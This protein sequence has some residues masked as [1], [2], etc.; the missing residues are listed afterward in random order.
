VH[1]GDIVNSA[2]RL[3][4]SRLDSAEIVIETE[5]VRGVLPVRLT[6]SDLYETD[7]HYGAPV[8]G[9]GCRIHGLGGHW[10][11]DPPEDPHAT[12]IRHWTQPVT[13]TDNKAVPLRPFGPEPAWCLRLATADSARQH[14][15]IP[16]P[17]PAVSTAL[18]A[19]LVGR[20]LSVEIHAPL[21]LSSRPFAL[22]GLLLTDSGYRIDGPHGWFL[23]GR[24]L[25]NRGWRQ[26]AHHLLLDFTR[27]DGSYAPTVTLVG[28]M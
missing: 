12:V 1:I 6:G 17:L 19:A 11:P 3:Y 9:D 25:V 14:S 26:Q 23:E 24:D 18:A 16:E 4:R 21:P 22:T 15:A 13:M 5:H 8:S 27:A 10:R 2:L 28:R 7:Y 20:A